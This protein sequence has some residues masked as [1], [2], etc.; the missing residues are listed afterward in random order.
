MTFISLTNA[1]EGFILVECD[2]GLS[3]RLRVLVTHIFFAERFH[4]NAKLVMIWDINEACPG[5]FL[6][7]FK[8]LPYVS[9]ATSSSRNMLQSKALKVAYFN[10]I[11]ASIAI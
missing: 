4:N 3:N 8:P 7:L 2:E 6:E 9:F 10:G 11:T 1:D 5:H